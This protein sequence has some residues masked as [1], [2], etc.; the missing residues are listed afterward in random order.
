MNGFTRIKLDMATRVQG[1]CRAHPSDDPAHAGLITRLDDRMSRAEAL[2]E[3][4]RSG[5]LSVHASVLSKD[6]LRATIRDHLQVLAGIAELVAVDQPGLE[7]RLPMPAPSISHRAFLTAARV[8]LSEATPQRELFLQHGMSA[9]FLEELTKLVDQY[10][11]VVNQKLAAKNAHVGANADL[12]AVT[13]E[14]M[15]VVQLRTGSIG[16]AIGRTTSCLRLG[17]APETWPGPAG[18]SRSPIRPGR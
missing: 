11:Q 12:E 1:F 13:A 7:A 15:L 14:I 16:C 2:A 8:A 9:T 3:Q 18:P 10:E 6:D 17:E 5:H 4:E